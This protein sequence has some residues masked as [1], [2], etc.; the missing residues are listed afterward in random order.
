MNF[1][2]NLQM[3]VSHMSRNKWWAEQQIVW[4]WE[5]R[6]TEVAESYPGGYSFLSEGEKGFIITVI[7]VNMK[8]FHIYINK[9]FSKCYCGTPNVYFIW[10]YK[11]NKCS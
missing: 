3:C 6:E 7:T 11:E 10:F 8:R 9:C 1:C 4:G 2:P 5:G